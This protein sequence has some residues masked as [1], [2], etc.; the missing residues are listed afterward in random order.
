MSVFDDGVELPP[1]FQIVTT[2]KGLGMRIVSGLVKQLRATFESRPMDRGKIFILRVPIEQPDTVQLEQDCAMYDA[3]ARSTFS[4]PLRSPFSETS[5]GRGRDR[6]RLRVLIV[7]D[8]A[9]LAMDMEYSLTQ[10]GF[11]VVGIADSEREAVLL[12]DQQRPDLVLMDIM[13]RDGDGL[14]AARA[15]A[16][17]EAQIV[18]VSASSDPATLAAAEALRPL[19]F[20]RKPYAGHELPGIL[21]RMLDLDTTIEFWPQNTRCFDRPPNRLPLGRRA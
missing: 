9:V 14:A 18:F 6:K 10:S 12:V 3:I 17:R 7:E 20:I 8:E 16:D 15:I 1:D 19:G 11:D 4:S 13:L 21:K 5:E 2:E